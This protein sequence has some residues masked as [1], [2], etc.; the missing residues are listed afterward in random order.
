MF[1]GSPLESSVEREEPRTEIQWATAAA[2]GQVW[3]GS[4]DQGFRIHRGVAVFFCSV[5]GWPEAAG[6]CRALGSGQ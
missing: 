5:A 6:Q 2:A 1:L 4:R 3:V